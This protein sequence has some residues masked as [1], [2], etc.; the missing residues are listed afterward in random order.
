MF[1]PFV[2]GKKQSNNDYEHGLYVLNLNIKFY[3]G[4]V[5]ISSIK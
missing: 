2:K 5:E 3:S 1:K 4:K